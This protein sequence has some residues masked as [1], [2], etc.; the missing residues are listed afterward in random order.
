[1]PERL[2]P[3]TFARRWP[4]LVEDSER[5]SELSPRTPEAVPTAALLIRCAQHP[6]LLMKRAEPAD[7][8]RMVCPAPDCATSVI[9]HLVPLDELPPELASQLPGELT[10]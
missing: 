1:M 5:A 2:D 10:R 8:E 7:G 6:E 4:W 3:E 9:P